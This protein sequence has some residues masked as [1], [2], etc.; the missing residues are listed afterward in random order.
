MTRHITIIKLF[1]RMMITLEI[2]NLSFVNNKFCRIAGSPISIKIPMEPLTVANSS[3]FGIQTANPYVNTFMR[4]F[5]KYFMRHPNFLDSNL[6]P[7]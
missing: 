1:L 6:G 7:K 4:V 5:N 3:K 2:V